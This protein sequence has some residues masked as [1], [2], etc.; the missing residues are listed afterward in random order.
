MQ[1]EKNFQLMQVKK[2]FYIEIETNQWTR[3]A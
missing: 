3:I 1:N 2:N